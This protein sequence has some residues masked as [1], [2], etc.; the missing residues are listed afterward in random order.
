[1]NETINGIIV[2]VC[3]AAIYFHWIKFELKQ[4]F[5]EQLEQVEEKLKAAAQ[6][7]ETEAH[8]SKARVHRR[9]A[10]ALMREIKEF[11]WA[12]TEVLDDLIAARR[13]LFWVNYHAD[14]AIAHSA[15]S[16]TVK[17]FEGKKFSIVA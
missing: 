6:A 8:A 17:I 12:N 16:T 4:Q 1:M 9:E 10:N 11:D 14:R 7:A 15:Q 2:I 5:A 3:L 13:Q